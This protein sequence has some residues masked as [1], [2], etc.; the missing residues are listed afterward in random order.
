MEDGNILPTPT[1][2]HKS[3]NKQVTNDLTLRVDASI[4]WFKTAKV[5]CDQ[6]GR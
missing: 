1:L 5:L 4:I 2:A 3:L 6:T